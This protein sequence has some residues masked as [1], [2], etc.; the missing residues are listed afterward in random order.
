MNNLPK[1]PA[2][3]TIRVIVTTIKEVEINFPYITYDS[4]IE[5][6]YYNYKENSC[7]IINSNRIE[8]MANINFGLEYPEV[9]KEEVFKVMDNT[10]LSITEALNK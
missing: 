9:K 6:Y 7:I 10:I 4:S 3:K 1:I 5:T 2:K 8:H